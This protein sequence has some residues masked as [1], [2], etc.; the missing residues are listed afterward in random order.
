MKISY[1]FNDLHL[2]TINKAFLIILI[3]YLYRDN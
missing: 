2:L 1:L 3:V